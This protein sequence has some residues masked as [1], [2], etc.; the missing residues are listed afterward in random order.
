VLDSFSEALAAISDLKRDGIVAD[1]AVGGAMAVIF[2]SEPT[3]TFDLD[4]FVRFHSPGMLVSLDAIYSWARERG[5]PEEAE[6]IVIAGIPVQVIP[7]HNALAEEAV[8]N[9]A[10]LDYEGQPVR[11]IR[12][13]Y[14]IAMYLEPS[15]RNRKRME[16]VAALLDEDNVDRGLLKRLLERYKLTLPQQ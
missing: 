7:A 12:P 4:V 16:R 11:V 1:Y 6:H 10:D 13:E 14:L 5:Y 3:A 8:A 9:A 15:A 2:W